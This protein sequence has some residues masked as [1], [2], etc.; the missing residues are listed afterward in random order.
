MKN[1]VRNVLAML[2]LLLLS[3]PAMAD[4]CKYRPMEPGCPQYCQFN[5]TSPLCR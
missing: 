1:Y 4:Y 3:S 5:P 2:S